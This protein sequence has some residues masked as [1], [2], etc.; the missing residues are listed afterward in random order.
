MSEIHIDALLPPEMAVRA[1]L[2]G[3]RKAE[4]PFLKMFML[5]VL[6]GAFIAL[7]SVFATTIGAGTLSVTPA[8][9]S[10]AFNTDLPYG[11]TRL[12]MGLVFSLGLVLVV[13]GGAELFT[14]N[15]LIVMA[16]ASGKVSA[17]GLMRNWIIVYLGNFIGSIG[18]AVLMFL[19]KQYT[20][21]ANAVGVTALRIGV[22][23]V[24]LEFIQAI[25]LGILCNALVCMAVWLTYSARSTMDRIAAVIFPITA[26]VAAGFEHSV[27]NMYF[28]PYALM[29]KDFDP[30][31]VAEVSENV[32]NLDLLTW[33]A[34]FVDNLLPVT[35]GNIIG[36]TVLVAAVYWAIFLRHEPSR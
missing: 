17:S 19:T 31:F 2:L 22:A 5:A 3:V 23:K 20:F 12:L 15:N 16:W 36:G 1:E 30:G 18:T 14:G 29:I 34:F 25:A 32:I 4:M 8:D 13:V 11:I 24:D 26:F 27:A 6:A 10:A 35:V 33:Q 9:G 21:G 28:I 7:G